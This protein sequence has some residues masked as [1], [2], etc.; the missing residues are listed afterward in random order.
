MAHK[1]LYITNFSDFFLEPEE[2]QEHVCQCAGGLCGTKCD[3]HNM[4]TPV[5]SS[6]ALEKPWHKKGI[7]KKAIRAMKRA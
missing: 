7:N 3:C 4:G 2:E 6:V 5:Q 1:I